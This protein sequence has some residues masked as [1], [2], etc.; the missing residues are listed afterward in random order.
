MNVF[1]YTN[2]K[3]HFVGSG[4][5]LINNVTVLPVDQVQHKLLQLF[6]GLRVFLLA[7][8][9]T[10]Q[11]ELPYPNERRGHAGSDGNRLGYQHIRI[12]RA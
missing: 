3:Q 8:A 6:H 10:E 5:R 2:T 9:A 1:T 11:L 4:Q 7:G 12:D